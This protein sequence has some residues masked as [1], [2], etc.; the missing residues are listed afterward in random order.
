MKALELLGRGEAGV[1][2][3]AESSHACEMAAPVV[4]IFGGT[5][6]DTV[7]RSGILVCRIYVRE[8]SEKALIWDASL[9]GAAALHYMDR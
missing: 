2:A 7:Q 6:L 5:R 8:T 4:L 1:I 9:R 3:L